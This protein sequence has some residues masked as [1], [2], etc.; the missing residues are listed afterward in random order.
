MARAQLVA[1][2]AGPWRMARSDGKIQAFKLKLCMLGLS[3]LK[4]GPMRVSVLVVMPAQQ[5]LRTSSLAAFS[6]PIASLTIDE[7]TTK[8]DLQL[9][10]KFPPL[11]LAAATPNNISLA[12]ATA[13]SAP[14][15]VARGTIDAE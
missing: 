7:P 14:M 13:A 9:D 8:G 11:P 15:F 6:A 4:E 1:S 2:A 12:A 3:P 10:P 5:N